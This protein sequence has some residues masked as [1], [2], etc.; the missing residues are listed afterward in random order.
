MWDGLRLCYNRNSHSRS[1]TLDASLHLRLPGASQPRAVP[2]GAFT[3]SLCQGSKGRPGPA[4]G[5][6]PELAL[7]PEPATLPRRCW[8]QG[9]NVRLPAERLCSSPGPRSRPFPTAGAT[10]RH[11]AAGE[12]SAA[13]SRLFLTFFRRH[14]RF[15]RKKRPPQS[16]MVSSLTAFHFPRGSDCPGHTLGLPAATKQPAARRRGQLFS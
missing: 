12:L 11:T 7:E 1:K 9:Y 5:Q 8:L 6:S 4:Q 13:A 14:R 10:G 2:R 15:C 3:S 16:V